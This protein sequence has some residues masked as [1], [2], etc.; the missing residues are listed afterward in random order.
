[1]ATDIVKVVGETVGAGGCILAFGDISLD[2]LNLVTLSDR[3][4]R[5][6]MA[7]VEMC[8]SAELANDP[9]VPERCPE[10]AHITLDLA[11]G[12]RL[13]D[14]LP[15]PRGMPGNPVSDEALEDKFRDCFAMAASPRNGPG[16]SPR[17]YGGLKPSTTC[18]PS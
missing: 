7:K 8:L 6:A 18:P 10:G 16:G 5:S 11:D 12:Q 15:R 1:L 2:H 14:F 3:R 4:L 9:T 17:G 13:R